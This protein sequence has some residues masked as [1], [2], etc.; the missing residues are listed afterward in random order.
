VPNVTHPTREKVQVL[1]FGSS[2]GALWPWMALLRGLSPRSRWARTCSKWIAFAPRHTHSG[3]APFRQA[4]GLAEGQK[5][6]NVK[7]ILHCATPLRPPIEMAE[8][9]EFLE[10]NPSFDRF[11]RY[12]AERGAGG[13]QG[14]RWHT[15]SAVSIWRKGLTGRG[16]FRPKSTSFLYSGYRQNS[17]HFFDC[18]RFD[19]FGQSG[20][21]CQRSTN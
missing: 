13:R 8:G 19:F 18:V 7:R 10:K 5:S 3:R 4:K 6:A 16:L 9:V 20:R 21:S 2:Y 12:L 11:G 15:R 14:T 1:G 17:H